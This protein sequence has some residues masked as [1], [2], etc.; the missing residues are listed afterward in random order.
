MCYREL[1]CLQRRLADT[2]ARQQQAFLDLK[3]QIL[4]SFDAA[5]RAKHQ[6]Q[7]QKQSE[8]PEAAPVPLLELE[9]AHQLRDPASTKHVSRTFLG[10][11]PQD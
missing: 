5:A 7:K 2:D 6:Q 11:N 9:P 1:Q 3:L 8:G 10:K 4:R